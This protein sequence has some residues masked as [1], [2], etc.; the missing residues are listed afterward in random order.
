[1]ACTISR[2]TDILKPK[3]YRKE[4]NVCFLQNDPMADV[5]A[6]QPID[7]KLKCN[8]SA[9]VSPLP[10]R[11]EGPAS[12][13]VPLTVRR[14]AVHYFGGNYGIQDCTKPFAD[15]VDDIG[16]LVVLIAFLT[17]LFTLLAIA[18]GR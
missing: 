9:R 14:R 8:R 7:V 17:A 4:G 3:T 13:N 18:G 11:G 10:P 12:S 5:L 16:G 15:A 1:M 2:K 6:R